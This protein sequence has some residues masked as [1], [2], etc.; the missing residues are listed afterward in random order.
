MQNLD[1]GRAGLRRIRKI[2]A[3]EGFAE[4][5]YMLIYFRAVF[6][7]IACNYYA[8]VPDYAYR[9]V[10]VVFVCLSDYGGDCGG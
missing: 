7:V 5:V 8:F 3:C 6:C 2:C 4:F 10:G 9:S 1:Q